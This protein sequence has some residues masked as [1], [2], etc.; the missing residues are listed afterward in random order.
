MSAGNE[1]SFPLSTM[2]QVLGDRLR[3]NEWVVR[4][5]CLYSVALFTLC[6]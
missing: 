2:I 4:L 3:V 1:Q 6:L 5:F